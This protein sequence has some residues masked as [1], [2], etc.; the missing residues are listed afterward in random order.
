MFCLCLCQSNFAEW[1]S[2]HTT[3][4]IENRDK[5]SVTRTETTYRDH[6]GGLEGVEVGAVEDDVVVAELISVFLP[7][8]HLLQHVGKHVFVVA[9]EERVRHVRLE[10]ERGMCLVTV[11]HFI[12]ACD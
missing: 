6:S 5:R 8:H 1:Q 2:C 9:N 12:I 3:N 10:G 4:F 11:N 7:H